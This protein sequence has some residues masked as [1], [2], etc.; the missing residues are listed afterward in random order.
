M[1][2]KTK[3][4]GN[5][6]VLFDFYGKRP[7][8]SQLV[9]LSLQHVLAA[10]VGVITPSMIIAGV[11]GLTD[12]EKTMMIRGTDLHCTG[13]VFTAVSAVSQGWCSTPGYHGYQLRICTD[14]DCDRR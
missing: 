14:P 2:E 6:N 10:I 8:M 9:P 11:C 1:K 12:A 5:S 4:L 3:E 7:E 13:Y